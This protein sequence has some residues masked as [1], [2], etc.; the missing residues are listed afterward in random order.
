MHIIRFFNFKCKKT[1][2]EE[3]GLPAYKNKQSVL[4]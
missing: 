1:A 2:I 4:E 3:I